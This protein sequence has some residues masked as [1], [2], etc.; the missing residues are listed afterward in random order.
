MNLNGNN[1][2]DI[3]IVGAAKSGTTSLFKMLERRP[4]CFRSTLKEP[5]FHSYRYKEPSYLRSEQ[6]FSVQERI[7]RLSDYKALYAEARKDQ[8]IVDASTQYLYDYESFT[9]SVIELYGDLA[10]QLKIVIILRDP[11]ARAWSHFQMHRADGRERLR[12]EEALLSDVVIR[13]IRSGYPDSFDYIGF[14]KYSKAIK[15]IR[16]H[17]RHVI[18]MSSDELSS[19]SSIDKLQR[20][21]G[22]TPINIYSDVRYNATGIP[23][24]VFAT[25]MMYL[26]KSKIGLLG[27][28]KKKIPKRMKYDFK[29]WFLA[30]YLKKK[31]VPDAFSALAKSLLSEEY[32][33][34][35]SMGITFND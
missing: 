29:V 16:E 24:G 18:V 4:D 8:F 3:Y 19:V 20:M 21:L 7:T 25:F 35:Q 17:F 14:S 28:L 1:L 32:D 11:V 30:K 5:Y 26:F 6:R 27:A 10:Q 12:F 23:K 33:N 34:L 9:R 22:F 2:P 13:R 15:Y 31:E